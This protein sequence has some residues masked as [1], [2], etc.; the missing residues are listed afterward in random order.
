[1]LEYGPKILKLEKNITQTSIN[2]VKQINDAK[3][4]VGSI[5]DEAQV[6]VNTQLKNLKKTVQESIKKALKQKKNISKCL[7]KETIAINKVDTRGIDKCRLDLQAALL[8]TN[9]V[10]DLSKEKSALSVNTKLC[11]IKNPWIASN[12]RACL[13]Q[14]LKNTE[15]KVNELQNNLDGKLE[16]A[17]KDSI[18]CIGV[19]LGNL[20]I[21]IEAVG[22]EFESCV[23]DILN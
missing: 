14:E 17:Q 3:Y 15:N 10:K 8:K 16:Q 12:L 5:A 19:K 9:V 23:N 18:A 4:L 13:D 2:E 1:M 6:S 11:A 7:T 22:I 20:D 21:S